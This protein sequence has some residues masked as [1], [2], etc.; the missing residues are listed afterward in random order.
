MDQLLA[1]RVFVRIAESGGF[2]KAADTLDVPRA[3]VSKLIQEL[4]THLRV[5]LFQRST[6]KVVVTEEGQ[7]YYPNAVKLLADL[8]EMDGRFADVHGK[9]RGRVRV[10][11]GS[12]F[13]NLIL[14]PRLPEFRR[15]F[16]DIQL[17]VGVSDRHADLI[18]EGVDC[19]IRGGELSD[20]SLVAR[21]IASLE[22]GT[23]ASA[24][25]LAER[26]T[27]GHPDDLREGHELSGYFSSLTGRPF[28]M[29]FERGGERLTVEPKGARAVCVNESTA[30]LTSLVSGLG[31]GQTFAFMAQPA[32]ARGELV[33]ILP[34][35]T[36]P[37]QP[38]HVVF[39]QARYNSARLRVF[40]DW[41]VELFAPYDSRPGAGPAR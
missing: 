39:A 41:V 37:V 14:L 35:W 31:I 6:R 22:W 30:H 34:K 10:D 5:K 17:D 13:A 7:S 20:A 3:T 4:E 11:I 15:R 26:G 32:V 36:R 33:R 40:V 12:S 27:P 23:Y 38:V 16:P 29:L 24:A 1:L 19:V 21:R 28:P 25:Y 18:G 9:P 8:D 2:G